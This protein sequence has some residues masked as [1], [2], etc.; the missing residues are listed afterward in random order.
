MDISKRLE[1]MEVPDPSI[2]P[3]EPLKVALMSA[4]KSAAIGVW[5]VAVPIFLFSAVMMK[6]YFHANLHLTGVFEE[7]LAYLDKDSSTS[8][9]TPV[10]FVLLPLA[11]VLLNVLAIAHVEYRRSLRQ[12]IITV[13]LRYLNILVCLVSFVVVGVI[14]LH[15]ILDR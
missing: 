15:T 11:G 5:L 10:F 3:N 8:W 14:L 12:L 7:M 2:G 1:Q 4:K 6:Y 9:I 13:K